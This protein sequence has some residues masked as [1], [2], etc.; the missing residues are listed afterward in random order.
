MQAV[1]L[2]ALSDNYI[3]LLSDDAGHALVVDPGEAAPV[4]AA[5]E[6][7]QLELTTIVLT[8]HHHDH[9]G[10][11]AELVERYAPEVIA[12]EDPR[13]PLASRR[14]GDGDVV[15]VARPQARFEVIAVPG[16]TRSHIAFFGEGHLF[17]G[18]TL[19]SLGCGRLFEGTP[20]QMHA[21]LS[22]LALLPGDTL[23]CC[24]HEYTLANAAF[25]ISVDP[26]NRELAQRREALQALRAAGQP[27]VPSRLS[28]EKALN[29]FLRTDD[30][31]IRAWASQRHAD[32]DAVSRFAALRDAKDHFS[33]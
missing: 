11:V 9:I 6:A 13:I 14:V 29:P 30:E 24:A 21:S 22:R 10:G 1:P 32:S 17:C 19:F 27:T 28:M 20:A 26:D 12:P 25:A 7:R 33:A 15:D 3:W 8:H 31:A 18:D 2:P 5:L 16:H 4:H 23:V